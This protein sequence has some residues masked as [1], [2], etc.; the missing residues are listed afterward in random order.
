L[1]RQLDRPHLAH[2]LPADEDEGGEPP[3]PQDQ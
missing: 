1:M 3:N 2:M